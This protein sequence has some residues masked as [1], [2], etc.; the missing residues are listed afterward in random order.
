MNLKNSNLEQGKVF[1]KVKSLQFLY[2]VDQTGRIVRNIKSKKQLLQRKNDQGY[3]FVTV[4]IKGEVK[5]VTIHSIVAEAW[6]G[7]QPNGYDIEHIDKDITNNHYTNLRYVTHIKNNLHS[8]INLKHP[9]KITSINE[10]ITFET[11]KECAI[12][13]AEKYNK[14]YET[15]RFKLSKRRRHIYDYDIQYLPCAE[16]GHA[17]STE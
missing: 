4:C 12:Y 6:I 8:V 13:I 9:I 1:R 14:S 16:T 2:E 7:K 15:V 11:M 10:S 5:S 17:H 3:Y